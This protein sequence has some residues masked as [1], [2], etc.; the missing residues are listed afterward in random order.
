M[1]HQSNE[2]YEYI[3]ENLR[4]RGHHNALSISYNKCS[5]ARYYNK[6]SKKNIF[7]KINKGY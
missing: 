2:L 7:V 3:D 5:F 1:N 6:Y 4:I